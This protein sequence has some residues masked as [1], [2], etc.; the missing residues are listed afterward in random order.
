LVS[1]EDLEILPVWLGHLGSLEIFGMQDCCNVIYLPESMKNL[2]TLRHLTLEE[3]RGLEILP[4]W[5]GQLTS[6]ENIYI[7]AC[8]KLTCLPESTKC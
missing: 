5:L 7:R 4:G 1:L 8:P 3:C 6:L 2:T